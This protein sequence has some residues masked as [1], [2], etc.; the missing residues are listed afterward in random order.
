MQKSLQTTAKHVG[1]KQLYLVA[2]RLMDIKFVR[3]MTFTD[4]TNRTLRRDWNNVESPLDFGHN[5]SETT[6]RKP[7]FGQ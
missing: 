4:L 1:A 7:F 5:A 2:K 6:L 3:R